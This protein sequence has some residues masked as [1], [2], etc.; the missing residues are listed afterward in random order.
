LKRKIPWLG[1]AAVVLTVTCLFIIVVGVCT[2]INFGS[3]IHALENQQS[4][5]QPPDLQSAIDFMKDQMQHLIWLLGVIVAGVGAVIA[6]FGLTTRRSVEEKYELTYSKLVAA[7][8][9]E[10]YKKQIV[11]LYKENDDNL[12]KF[13]NE[14]RARGYNTKWMRASG[15]DVTSKLS[16]ASIV[17][18]CVSNASDTLYQGIA[19]WCEDKEIHCVLYCPK[20]KLE[21]EFM[22]E[23]HSYMST[24][25]QIAKLRESLYTLLYLAP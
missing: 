24:S 3:R 19:K 13:Q 5:P 20:I 21:D 25:I 16:G 6:F 8:D 12:I 1:I 22:R 9:T 2:Y 17:I 18:Y 11:F 14:I 4:P 10:V 23:N 15:S 7:K